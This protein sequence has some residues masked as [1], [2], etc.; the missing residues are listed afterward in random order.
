MVNK[1]AILEFWSGD[2][3][4]KMTLGGGLGPLQSFWSLKKGIRTFNF[5]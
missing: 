4:E 1:M 2:F 5:R 3:R